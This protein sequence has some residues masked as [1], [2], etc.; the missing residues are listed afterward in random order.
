MCKNIGNMFNWCRFISFMF[1]RRLIFPFDAKININI[2]TENKSLLPGG[3]RWNSGARTPGGAS[4]WLFTS[5][6]KWDSVGP[7]EVRWASRGSFTSCK[8]K[9]GGAMK[10]QGGADEARWG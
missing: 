5:D 9:R 3:A 1:F 7:G 2:N 10:G 6:A 4:S 8:S